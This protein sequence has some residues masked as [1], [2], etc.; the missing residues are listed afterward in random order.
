VARNQAIRDL[1]AA[2]Q[3]GDL[4]TRT[5]LGYPPWPHQR[6]YRWRDEL[7][8][9]VPD[10]VPLDRPGARR[11]L[12]RVARPV[13]WSLGDLA[14]GG[15]VGRGRD[16]WVLG[17]T[18]YRRPDDGGRP[19]CIYTEHLRAQLGDRLLF[20][21]TNA[22][23]L[24]PLGRDDVVYIDAVVAAAM[25]AGRALAPL[26]LLDPRRRR[27]LAAFAPTPATTVCRDA[28][29][30]IAT[31]ALARRWLRRARPAALFVLC[32]YTFF[33]PFLRA[34]RALGIP[35]IELQHGIIYESHPGYIYDGAPALRHTPDHIVVF[36]EHFGELLE[37]ECSRWRGRWSVGGHPWLRRRAAAADGPRD[38]VVVFSAPD[39]ATRG[40]LAA[41]L[42]SLRAGLDRRLRVV[43]KPHP[44]ELDAADRYRDQLGPGVELAGNLDDGYRMLAGAVASLAVNSTAAI[45]ALAF[46]CRSVVLRAPWCADDI[47]ALIGDGI[48]D[49]VGDGAEAAA[50]IARPRDPAAGRRVAGRLFG[51]DRP[52]PDFAALIAA[53]QARVAGA[54]VAA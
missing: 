35:V 12:G 43:I 28:V 40:L 50:L 45:E 29:Y 42:P 53:V 7:F 27:E 14:R 8:R 25:G 2:E 6:L 21:E 26:L 54:A 10:F 24:A 17:S 20:L 4:W 52:E 48:L 23:H 30:G 33:I 31:E 3:R 41:A 19:Q 37:R 44:L 47:R 32:S 18:G 1:V 39:A 9:D 49:G 5:V 16:L 22:A 11:L 15:P 36:G 46:G 34:A 51:I 38:S 13:A